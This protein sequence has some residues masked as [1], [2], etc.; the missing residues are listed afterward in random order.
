MCIKL[1][2]DLYLTLLNTKSSTVLS[3]TSSDE[4]IQLQVDSS[5]TWILDSVFCENE[6]CV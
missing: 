5:L 6:F 3:Q 4:T 2:V 1:L